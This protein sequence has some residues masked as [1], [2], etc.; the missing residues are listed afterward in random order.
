MAQNAEPT[1]PAPTNSIRMRTTV[2]WASPRPTFWRVLLELWLQDVSLGEL[3]LD[4]E[5]GQPAQR[6]IRFV[7]RFACHLGV[8][9]ARGHLRQRDG[10]LESGQRRAEAEV[11]TLAE[12]QVA[13]G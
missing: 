13:N 1:P 7:L 8:R 12:P 3:H 11:R 10:G 2:R 5:A 4:L 9:E 6:H